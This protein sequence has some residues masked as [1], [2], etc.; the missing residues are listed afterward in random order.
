MCSSLLLWKIAYCRSPVSSNVHI[1][2]RC[3]LLWRSE[4]NLQ[5]RR[6]CEKRI[7]TCRCVR[8][9][10]DSAI[11]FIIPQ[12][13]KIYIM[14]HHLALFRARFIYF[15]TFSKSVIFRRRMNF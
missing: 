13:L 7:R 9:T 11:H 10:V 1:L 8:S 4:R 5:A 12:L 3:G 14:L 15:Q 6:E 2:E